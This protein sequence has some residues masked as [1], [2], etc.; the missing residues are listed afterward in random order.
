MNKPMESMAGGP[1]GQPKSTKW[2]DLGAHVYIKIALLAIP[3]CI[4]FHHPLYTL[5]RQWLDP[6]WSHGFLIPAFSLYFLHQKRDALLALSPR[7]SYLGLTGLIF[8]IFFYP[9]NLV[10]FQFAYFDWL[11]MLPMIASIVLF[12]GGW[13]M[14]YYT[15]LPIAYLFFAIPFP[16]RYY[17]LI[18]IPMREFAA[19]VSTVVLNWIPGVQ[20]VASGAV[21]EVFF[22][23]QKLEPSLDVAEACSG[24]RLLMA[25]VA[26]GV[27]MAY[28]HQRPLWQRIVLLISTFPIAILCNVI[29]VTVTAMIYILWDPR[30]ARGIYHDILGILMLPLAFGLY[31]LLAWFMSN[32]FME[33]TPQTESIIVRST[34][35]RRPS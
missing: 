32:L 4:L 35:T 34:S 21:I 16:D 23:G 5:F 28:L 22:R 15:W 20:S 31:G 18:T 3:F 7:P 25:F 12:L 26:L 6:T 1:I 11:I 9:L 27:A 24:M 33:E 30:Y 19:G 17:K 10:Q 8:C 14:L 13:K 29:R 2:L